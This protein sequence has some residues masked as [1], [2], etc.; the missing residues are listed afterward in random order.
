[1]QGAKEL[2]VSLFQTL[3]L[4]LFNDAEELTLEEVA[5]QTG[6]G[7]ESISGHIYHAI[8]CCRVLICAELFFVVIS[9]SGLTSQMHVIAWHLEFA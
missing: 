7:T 1:M 3:T 2:Q 4:L 9:I 6:I 8:C 5:H